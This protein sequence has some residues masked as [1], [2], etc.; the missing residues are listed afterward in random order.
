MMLGQNARDNSL[1]VLCQ[2]SIPVS[3]HLILGKGG[4]WE[5]SEITFLLELYDDQCLIW[6]SITKK[7]NEK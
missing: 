4:R 6:P 1:V 7:F 3:F 2:F 5:A